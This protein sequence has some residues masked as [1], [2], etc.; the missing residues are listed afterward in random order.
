MNIDEMQEIM[1]LITSLAVSFQT[2]LAP[3]LQTL[4]TTKYYEGGEAAQVLEHY[5]AMLNKVNEIA[6]L[7]DTAN[8]KVCYLIQ[9]WLAQDQILAQ[10]FYRRLEPDSQLIQN[11]HTLSRGGAS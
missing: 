8:S 9:H 6:D 11:L 4:S 7:Y 3:K 1:R 5:S 10:S 2:V